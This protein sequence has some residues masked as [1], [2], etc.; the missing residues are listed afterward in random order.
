[1]NK[2]ISE[3]PIKITVL[4]LVFSC[5]F[6]LILAPYVLAE[7]NVFVT[8]YECSDLNNNFR[9][10][11][12]TEI[13]PSP[14]KGQAVNTLIERGNGIYTGFKG[15]ISWRS[16]LE[17][18]REGFLVRPIRSQTQA[19]DMSGQL[20]SVETQEFNFD[21]NKAIFTRDDKIS[22]RV[23]KEEFR[24]KE[25]IVNRLILGLYIQQF[26]KSGKDEAFLDI[27]NSEPRLIRCRLYMVGE[28]EIEIGGVKRNAIKLCLD[29]QLGLL[30][31]V[32]VLIPRSYVWHSAEGE[33]E[34]LK[35]NGLELNL[36][37]P[38]VEIKNKG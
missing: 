27:L 18:K 1:M 4:N 35:Y 14:E 6:F 8:S 19:F 3:R 10:E 21:S 25:D 22:G 24:F 28:E 2:D 26:L 5:L 32:K 11:A 15:D 20:I 38:I 16:E 12:V 33:F 13:M 7:N 23:H 9:W 17:Y 34:W 29:P 37:S 30:S 36:N 31:F